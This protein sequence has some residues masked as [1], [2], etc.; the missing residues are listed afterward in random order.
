MAGHEFWPNDISLQ[1]DTKI[2]I[3]HLL[4]SAQVTDSCLL[5]LVLA[6]ARQGKLAMLVSDAR[7]VSTL[8]L[9][10]LSGV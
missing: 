8:Y 7:K 10:K 1:D 3:P 4:N 5:V 6:V 2:L 9:V